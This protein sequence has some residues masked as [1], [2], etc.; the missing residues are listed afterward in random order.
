[1]KKGT[2]LISVT[3][4]L[5]LIFSVAL[6]P[7]ISVFADGWRDYRD[8][9]EVPSE[10][11]SPY[12]IDEA[13]A[14]SS[15]DDM[16]IE[17]AVTADSDE[18]NYDIVVVIVEGLGDYTAQEL[19]DDCYKYSG[20]AE[21]GILF[22]L[23]MENREWAIS[24]A[25]E[26]V[27]AFPETYQKHMYRAMKEDLENDDWTSAFSFGGFTFWCGTAIRAYEENG[28]AYSVWRDSMDREYIVKVIIT[29][30]LCGAMVGAVFALIKK[31]LRERNMPGAEVG[32]SARQYMDGRVELVD[33]YDRFVRNEHSEHFVSREK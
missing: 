11:I 8:R 19:A 13:N 22:L 27:N 1:M 14:L 28:T 6:L 23:S 33:Q 12:L 9:D 20:F 32:V 5:I 17:M 25:G 24:V 7:S 16:M 30:V 2:K 31:L 26:A 29:A 18:Y 3:L 4:G 10:R 15:I 21:N